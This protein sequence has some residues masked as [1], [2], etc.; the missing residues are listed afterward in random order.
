MFP[1]ASAGGRQLRRTNRL[2]TKTGTTSRGA[3]GRT[4]EL[5]IAKEGEGEESVREVGGSGVSGLVGRT[6]VGTTDVLGNKGPSGSGVNK[7]NGG[8]RKGEKK[9]ELTVKSFLQYFFC[10]QKHFCTMV[11]IVID[12]IEATL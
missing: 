2:D 5:G 4:L 1:F 7:I 6:V 8:R 3:E 12:F 9:K 11:A 10:N